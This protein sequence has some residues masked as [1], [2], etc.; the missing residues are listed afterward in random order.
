[1]SESLLQLGSS[2]QT[3]AGVKPVN[4]DAVAIFCP[5]SAYLQQVKGQ[6]LIVADG[7]SAAEAGREA[8]A[9]AVSRFI[10]EY[11]QTPDTWS[12]SHSGEQVLSAINLHLYRKSHEFTDEHKGYLTT[13]SAVVLKGRQLHFFHVGDSRIYLYRNGEL[14]QLT[15]DHVANLGNNHR[16]LS[17]ALGMDNLLHVDYGSQLLEQDDLLLLTSDGV[18]DFLSLQQL[19]GVLGEDKD[20]DNLSQQL[21]QMALD[22]GS[23]DN[24]SA[25]VAKVLALPQQQVDDFNA[26]LTRLPFPPPLSPGMKL[27]GYEVLEVLYNSARSQLYLVKDL[28]DD[29]QW[30]M[31]TPSPNFSDDSHYIDRFIQEQWIG[32]RIHHP[33]VVSI[34]AQQRPRTALYY[35]MEPVRGQDLDGWRASNPKAGPKRR[36]QLIRQLAE[37]LKAFHA[38]DAVHQDVKP[39]NVMIDDNDKLMLVDFGSVFVAGV[40]ELYRPIEHPGALG[41]ATYADPNYLLGKNPG[42]QGDVYSLATLCYELFTGQLPYGERIADCRSWADYDKLRYVS[43]S[44][45]NPVIP[46]WFDRALERG[47][48]F[49]LSLRYQTID[50][51][52]ADLNHPN[53]E[54]LKELPPPK[55]AGKLMLWKLISGFWFITLLVVIY[56]FSQT[57]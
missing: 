47:V 24:L 13:F 53:P 43:A 4:E 44:R 39:G 49:D 1:M 35:L 12:V 26:Q 23:N 7:I 3:Q 14:Q 18:H 9:S 42:C 29:S 57:G 20:A 30:V 15:R 37:A 36:I 6:V 22:A 51:L 33:N 17:R 46:L 55:E 50:Q 40:A 48:S 8:S 16:F 25:L 45:H 5:D 32:S 11:Y 54:L 27:D 41:T 38:N 34:L 21:I 31:K 2:A 19:S 56:L 28:Q 52:M 10:L